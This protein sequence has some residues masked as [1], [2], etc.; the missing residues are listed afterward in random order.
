MASH[1]RFVIAIDGPAASGKSSVAAEVAR[2]LDA[3]I[4]D[5]GAVYRALTLAALDQGVSPEDGDA[6]AALIDQVE[7][8]V[9]P[10]SELD[11]RQYDVRIDGR[12]VTWEVR[13][14]AVDRAV[15][16]VSAH[17]RVRAGLLELQR[18][19]GRSGR[20]VMPGRDIGTVVMP[21]AD[22][23]IWLD[24]SLDERARRRQRE[25]EERGVDVSLDV[26]REEMEIRDRYD[27]SRE[28]APMEPARDAFVIETSGKTIEEV[29]DEV[30]AR[31][32][33]V[34]QS[35]SVGWRE[36]S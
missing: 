3:L 15:S 32:N 36:R 8:S 4:F 19:I 26:V 30:I 11:G 5:T 2:R 35:C 22:L 7:I 34:L 12:D 29:I 13:D 16:P 31:A 24:A 21:D 1:E 28:E 27:S 6:L 20:V 9:I 17:A 25:L 14:P 23:K 33:S 10:P 18:E